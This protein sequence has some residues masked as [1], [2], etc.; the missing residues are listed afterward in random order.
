[1]KEEEEEE[2]EEE[3]FSYLDCSTRFLQL[4]ISILQRI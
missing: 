4:S 1:L 3:E 2:E